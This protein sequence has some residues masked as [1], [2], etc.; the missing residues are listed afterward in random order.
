M[1]RVERLMQH[2]G[3]H[4]VVRGRPQRQGQVVPHRPSEPAVSCET[5]ESAVGTGL[6]LRQHVAGFRLCSLRHRSVHL[7]Y[8]RWWVS[9]A[10]RT[11]FVLDALE[12]TPYARRPVDEGSLICP[13][14]G[15][16]VRVDPL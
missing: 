8:R 12:H 5:A 14:T 4:G 1:T 9:G 7:A 10:A 16:S 15:V 13:A 6:P 3:L 11:D 2:V